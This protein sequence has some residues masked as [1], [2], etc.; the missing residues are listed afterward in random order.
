ML[1]VQQ[2]CTMNV[3]GIKIQLCSLLGTDL[4]EIQPVARYIHSG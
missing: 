4:L 2:P 3:Y 1:M